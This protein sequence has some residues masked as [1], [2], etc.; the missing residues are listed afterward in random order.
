MLDIHRNAG[1]SYRDCLLRNTVLEVAVEDLDK[2]YKALDRAIMRYHK[3]KM[4][5]INKIIRDLWQQTY[6]GRGKWQ[7]HMSILG[8]NRF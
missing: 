4:D 1:E 8:G 3:I 5:E 6:R 7:P 2:Y